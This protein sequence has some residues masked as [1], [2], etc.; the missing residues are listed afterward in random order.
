MNEHNLRPNSERTTQELQENGRKGGI[1]SAEK[2][3][4]RKTFKE[5]I[6][7]AL[8]EQDVE[9]GQDNAVAIV[10]SLINKAKQG[11]NKAFEILRDTVGEKP[12]DKNELY[13]LPPIA[14]VQFDDAADIN[15]IED[16]SDE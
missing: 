6:N 12:S 15:T 1:K 14:L 8:Q 2:R 13:T 7:I 16:I 3:K 4:E 10:A 9:T 5:L 11:D